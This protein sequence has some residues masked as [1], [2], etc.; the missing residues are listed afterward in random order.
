[1]QGKKLK[2]NYTPTSFNLENIPWWIKY[3]MRFV[4]LICLDCWNIWKNMLRYSKSKSIKETTFIFF[5]WRIWI[6]LVAL[7][8]YCCCG[9]ETKSELPSTKSKYFFVFTISNILIQSCQAKK[10]DSFICDIFSN[11][12]AA[13]HLEILFQ[14]H[15]KILFF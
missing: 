2:Q 9:N 10:M 1:M 14:T 4:F 5:A 8:T 6:N 7:I 13:K 12:L 15:Q 11:I 3:F